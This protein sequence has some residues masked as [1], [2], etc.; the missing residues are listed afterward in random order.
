MD[1]PQTLNLILLLSWWRGKNMEFFDFGLGFCGV[2]FC[3]S[4]K[5]RA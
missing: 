3:V 2:H 1:K 4:L 5:Y